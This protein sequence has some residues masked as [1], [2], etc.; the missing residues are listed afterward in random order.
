[1]RVIRVSIRIVAIIFVSR[2]VPTYVYIRFT[3][4]L[5]WKDLY[6]VFSLSRHF[7]SARFSFND[8]DPSL[9]IY[10]YSL[11][12]LKFCWANNYFS[13]CSQ[14]V[15]FGLTTETSLKQYFNNSIFELL[16]KEKFSPIQ[17][18]LIKPLYLHNHA[19]LYAQTLKLPS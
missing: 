9:R 15:D 14:E 8:T 7:V 18:V 6:V 1:M 12:L 11:V 2:S 3:R 16:E 13:C 5:S 19:T 10:F 17:F 4:V